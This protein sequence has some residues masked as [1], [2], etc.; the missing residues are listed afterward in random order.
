MWIPHQTLVSNFGEWFQNGKTTKLQ[1][2]S[3]VNVSNMEMSPNFGDGCNLQ[4]KMLS[5]Q[6]S[7]VQF[8]WNVYYVDQNSAPN[9]E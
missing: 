3:L 8:F 5:T 2:Q 6:E 1:H 7:L 4:G 9:F